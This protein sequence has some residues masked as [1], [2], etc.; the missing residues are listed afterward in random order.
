VDRAREYHGPEGF[1]VP[2]RA[3]SPSDRLLET[4]TGLELYAVIL[5]KW[6]RVIALTTF[7]AMAATGVVSKF[8]FTKWYRA[9]AIV[10]P[11][12]QAAVETRMEGG[13]ESLGG[14][15]GALMGIASDGD[16]EA[17]EYMTILKSFSFNTALIARHHLAP[18]LIKDWS[19]GVKNPDFDSREVRW[20]IYRVMKKRLN[21][22]YSLENGTLS[23]SYMDR[24]PLAAER[25]L[26]YY[27]ND[28]RD[29]L[30]QQAIRDAKAAVMSLEEEV[31]N[32]SDPLL[33]Q[34]LYRVI[35][36]QV[37][38]EKLAQ[39]QADFA[40][41]VLEAPVTPYKPYWPKTLLNCLLVGFLVSSVFGGATLL[42]WRPKAAAPAGAVEAP[43]ARRRH[44]GDRENPA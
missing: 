14:N 3:A 9:T 31:K 27:L 17:R 40:F 24:D 25:I 6:W 42:F 4:D 33:V 12:S 2:Y 41:K 16:A 38:R 23:I 11:I 35:A 26:G 36:K 43:Q 37:Q 5:R 8:V 32:T 20:G 28:L 39:V 7:L 1:D 19:D 29:Q 15:L 22:D 34:S 21:F 44:F 10:K 30:R 13:L 18:D